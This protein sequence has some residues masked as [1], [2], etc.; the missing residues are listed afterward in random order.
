[1]LTLSSSP[2]FIRILQYK[3]L[4]LIPLETINVLQGDEGGPLMIYDDGK[5]T[6]L[7]VKSW[8]SSFGCALPDKPSVFAD[9]RWALPWI[10]SLTGVPF[11]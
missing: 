11:D 8:G 9:V 10:S 3:F 5:Y 2:L 7:G 4:I 6:I 1:M